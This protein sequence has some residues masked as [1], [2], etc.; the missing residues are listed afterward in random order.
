MKASH[1]KNKP[2]WLRS[3]DS[4]GPRASGACRTSQAPNIFWWPALAGTAA[5]GEAMGQSSGWSSRDEASLRNTSGW[6][7][8]WGARRTSSTTLSWWGDLLH[9]GSA[10]VAS[11]VI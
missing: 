1:N 4:A 5:V 7:R 9:T 6:L 2:W 8:C 11:P 3:S 10:W